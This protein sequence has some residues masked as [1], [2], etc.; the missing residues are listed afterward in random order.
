MFVNGMISG[1]TRVKRLYRK[2]L[3]PSAYI[4]EDDICKPGRGR[5]PEEN[6]SL[7]FERLGMMAHACNPSHLGGRNR[8]TI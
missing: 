7:Y 3:L 2:L 8:I 1:R 6:C 5:N 4:A